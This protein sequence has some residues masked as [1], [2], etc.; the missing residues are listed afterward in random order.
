MQV[1]NSS[2]S[3][4][5]RFLAKILLPYFAVIG[6]GSIVLNYA[7]ER[8]IIFNDEINGAYK[9]KRIIEETHPNEI[10]IIGSS[11]AEGSY[12]P[13]SLG[14]NFFNYGI[15]G[16]G[17][18]VAIFF[19]KRECMKPKKTPWI[20][21]NIDLNGL[22]HAH[23]NI[24][25]YIPNARYTDIQTIL[26]KDHKFYRH[27]PLVKYFGLYE[28]YVRDFLNSKMQLTKVT[29]KGAS[30]EQKVLPPI[31][32][33]GLVENR[34]KYGD[35]LK[36]DQSLLRALKEIITS[37]PEREFVFV[38]APYHSSYYVS[39]LYP[40]AGKQYLSMLRSFK[41]THVLD[42]GHMALS[43]DMYF[44]TTHLRLNGAVVFC[45]ALR[46]SLAAIGVR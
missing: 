41:N 8:T 16:T 39:Y 46:D 10:A 34:T 42:F 40:K 13:D 31:Q 35:T 29:N 9:I 28:T 30:I 17:T 7:F 15:A 26:G 23:G 27:L 36:M 21:I 14:N 22:T 18:D 32:F 5:K 11:R 38:V 1:Q 43:D 2:I 45:R 24:A 33:A 4:F 37:H 6:L 20:I 25:N 3:N 19:L 44:N 12:M